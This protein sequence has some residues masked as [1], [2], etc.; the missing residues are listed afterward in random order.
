MFSTKRNS[1]NDVAEET[2]NALGGNLS[3]LIY[4]KTPTV[5]KMRMKR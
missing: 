1:Q 5:M 3:L 4:Q 2:K